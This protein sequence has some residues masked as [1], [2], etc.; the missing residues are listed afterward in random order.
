[1]KYQQKN[2]KQ[3]KIKIMN[4]LFEAL[5][6][7]KPV[8]NIPLSINDNIKWEKGDLID[9]HDHQE[10][11]TANGVDENGKRYLAEWIETDGQF[12]EIDNIEEE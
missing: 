6:Q 12:D 10:I 8:K 11:F 4:K 3:S 9:S 2:F 5:L 7:G 1:M